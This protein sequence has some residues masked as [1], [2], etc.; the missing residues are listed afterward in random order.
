MRGALRVADGDGVCVQ[1]HSEQDGCNQKASEAGQG[2]VHGWYFLAYG[3][4]PDS[5]QISRALELECIL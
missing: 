3:S 2:T 4:E 5:V 1:V